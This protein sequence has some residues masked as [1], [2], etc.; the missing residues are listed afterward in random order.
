MKR[1]EIGLAL[2]AVLAHGVAT[3]GE[4]GTEAEARKVLANVESELKANQ[5]AAIA[6]IN[7]G[8]F[9]DRD[10][11]PFCAGPDAL[12]TAH[13]VDRNRIGRNQTEFK[14]A[15]GKAYGAEFRAVAKA[16]EVNKVSYV[17]PRPGGKE[18]VEKVALVTKVG[19][20]VC[21]VGYYK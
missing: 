15:N 11:Y 1:L 7:R 3:A 5:A 21:G 4:F 16:G 20:Q 9:N 6:K 19:D 8:G 13:G 2:V 14:D 10:L 17:Y 12:V 18:P